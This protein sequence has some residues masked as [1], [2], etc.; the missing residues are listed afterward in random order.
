V[1][2]TE[3][4]KLKQKNWADDNNIILIGSQNNRGEKM[5]TTSLDYNLFQ[6]LS[7]ETILDFSNGDGNELGNGNTP[8][9]MQALHSSSA[10]AV[11]VFDYWKGTVDKA[12]IAKSLRIPSTSIK[13]IIFE[14]KYPIIENS[15]A[16]NIDVVFEYENGSCSAIECK[17]TEPFNKRQGDYGLKQKYLDGFSRWDVIPEIYN[18]ARTISPDD[19]RFEKLHVAQLIKHILGLLSHYN[20]KKNKFRL[21]Y[22]YY[23]AFGDDGSKHEY[24]IQEFKKIINKDEIAFQTMSWQELICKLYTN[25]PIVHD[26]YIKYIVERYL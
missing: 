23:G 8:G 13:N 17:F 12:L 16:P 4:I 11:N 20:Y 2:T 24:E 21:I 1:K 15:I 9:K 3:F 14:K 10:L 25:C 7:K 19:K 6:P 18:L 26:K 22:L 5:Y